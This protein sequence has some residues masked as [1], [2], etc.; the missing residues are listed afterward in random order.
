MKPTAVD[1]VY[2]FARISCLALQ[3]NGV[4]GRH[5][6]HTNT[7]TQTGWRKRQNLGKTQDDPEEACSMRRPWCPE[8]FVRLYSRLAA[9]GSLRVIGL[10]NCKNIDFLIKSSATEP[11]RSVWVRGMG[12]WSAYIQDKD[13]RWSDT[14]A[15][16]TYS[17]EHTNGKPRVLFMRCPWSS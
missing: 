7:H 3:T 6:P 13:T 4:K 5:K 15:R 11:P 8:P 2:T 17:G 10:V 12:F 1:N 16:A 14:Y 9:W